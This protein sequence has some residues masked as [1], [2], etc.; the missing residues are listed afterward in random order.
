[1][2]LFLEVAIFLG[3]ATI[4]VPVFRRLGL[5]DVLG[6]LGAGLVIGPWGAGFVEHPDAILHFAEAG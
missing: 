3:A 6:Y 5:G 2:S 1:M 4:I